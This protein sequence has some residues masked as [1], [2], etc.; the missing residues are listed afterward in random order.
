[1][2]ALTYY[3]VFKKWGGGILLALT[4]YMYKYIKENWS[5]LT[6][7]GHNIEKIDNAL[8]VKV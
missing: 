3:I 1:M 4:I 6:K 2:L 5:K 7:M 8:I